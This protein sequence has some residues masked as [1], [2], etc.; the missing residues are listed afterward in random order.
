MGKLELPPAPVD[1]SGPVKAWSEPVVIPT[2][3]PMD[4]DKNPMFLES[5][6][7]QGSSGRVYPLPFIDRIASD[8]EPR[9]WQAWHLENEFVRLMILPE[10]GG[11]IHIGFDKI[12]GYDFFYRQNVIKPALVGLAGPWISGGVEFNW[13]Q[14]HRPATFMPVNTQM[15]ASPDGSITIWCGDHDPMERMRGAHGVCLHPGSAAV[16]VKVRLFNRTPYT[17]TF[18]WWAN[19]ATRV[20]EDY[21]SIFPPDVQA[22]ADHA[23]RAVSSFPLC[24][25]RYYGID[26]GARAENGIAA[27]QRPAHFIPRGDY[28]PNDLSRYANIPVPTSYMAIGSQYDFLAGYDHAKRA[29]VV[30]VANHHIAP[31][32]KQWTWGNHEFGYAWDRNLTDADGPYIELMAGVYTDNQPDFSFLGPYETKVFHQYWFPIRELSSVQDANENG[33][34]CLRREGDTW[35]VG[36]CVT[37]AFPGAKVV[38][39]SGHEWTC[40]L[41]PAKTFKQTMHVSEEHCSV[42]VFAADGSEIVKFD[43]A[44]HPEPANPQLAMEPPMPGEIKSQDELYL[45]GVHLQQYRHATRKPELYW[46]EALRREPNDY[47]SNTAM[48]H[49]YLRRGEFAKAERHLRQAITSLTRFNYNPADGEAFYLLGLTLRFAG[50]LNGAYDALYKSTWNLAWTAAGYLALAEIDMSRSQWETALTHVERSLAYNVENMQARNLKVL[51]L[52]KLGREADGFLRE[53]LKLDPL[54]AWARHL[55]GD[56]ARFPNQQLLDIAFDFAR[57]GLAVKGSQILRRADFSAKD[58]S[59]PMCLY[60]LAQFEDSEELRQRAQAASADY[61]FPSRLEEMVLLEEQ[62]K[63]DP[64][65]ARA[66][67]YLGNLLYDQRRHEEAIDCWRKSAELQ[68]EF[69]TVWRNLGI[70]Y[71]NT[72]KDEGRALDAFERAF[73]AQPDDARVFFERDQ[74]WKRTGRAVAERLEEM[75]KRRDLVDRRDDLSVE[76]AALYHQTGQAAKGL[77]L[78]AARRFQPWEGGEGLPTAQYV[79]GHITLGRD[80]LGRGDAEGAVT[81]CQAALAIPENLGEARHVLANQSNIFYWLGAAHHAAGREAAARAWWQRAVAHSGDFQQMA[82]QQFSEMTFYSAL[83]LQ[84][85]QEME[86]AKRLI[87]ELAAYAHQLGRTKGRIDY[88]ATSLPTMLLFD[89]DLDKRQRR[90]ALVLKAQAEFLNGQKSEAAKALEQVLQDDPSSEIAFDML[91]EMPIHAKTT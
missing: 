88:F 7:Y 4:A 54:D 11:R 71:F 24:N 55:A 75:E 76:L 49:F 32:K 20:N 48:G 43:P 70:G 35:E 44:A 85:L 42:A 12:N 15:E 1:C 65:D 3:A 6:V 53:S 38:V 83:S 77:A 39:S 5:R 57:C 59:V 84:R 64:Q 18:L 34:V 36:V 40:D 68:P 73:A 72:Y 30:H 50:D 90:T 21:Q 51:A 69:A 81:H 89:D 23:R 80:A 16:E 41:E 19:V 33:A 67:Y 66:F 17:Q 79:R 63:R 78:L 58:G 13:P 56:S 52:R 74:L 46:M 10:I 31:G 82:V 9:Q 2:Y 29:G 22:V 91:Q 45:I 86:R 26:Y 25:G 27:E 87:E 37:R 47:R 14:H 61:C 8:P 60:A 28:A 62:V